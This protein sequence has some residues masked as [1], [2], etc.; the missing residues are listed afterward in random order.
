M[1]DVEVHASYQVLVVLVGHANGHLVAA[2]IERDL[3]ASS[4]VFSQIG[5]PAL[6]SGDDLL[7]ASWL[8]VP[9]RSCGAPGIAR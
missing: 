6:A 1:G 7:I 4:R 2:G 9:R 8:S 5:A 3:L